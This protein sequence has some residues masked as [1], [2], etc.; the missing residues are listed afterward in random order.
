MCEL[1]GLQSTRKRHQAAL[2]SK[3]SDN[4][5]AIVV[6]NPN[7]AIR[8]GQYLNLTGFGDGRFLITSN[9]QID[10]PLVHANIPHSELLTSLFEDGIAVNIVLRMD[11]DA[12][13]VKDVEQARAISRELG[14][15][16]NVIFIMWNI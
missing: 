12:I 11:Q 7:T 1:L 13:L 8:F 5:Q 9:V 14:R 2:M 3:L 15:R 6:D 4:L 16:I 10:R